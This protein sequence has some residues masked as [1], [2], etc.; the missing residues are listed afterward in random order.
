MK[1]ERLVKIR[2]LVRYG[3]EHPPN[4]GDVYDADEMDTMDTALADA[5]GEID[6]LRALL[7]DPRGAELV[8]LAALSEET[9]YEKGHQEVIRVLYADLRRQADA[10]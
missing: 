10:E 6:R 8:R 2:D 5:M 7:V 1:A 9:A 4:P 3:A